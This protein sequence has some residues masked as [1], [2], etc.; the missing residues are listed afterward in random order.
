MTTPTLPRKPRKRALGTPTR[1][2]SLVA[3]PTAIVV[4][5]SGCET[6]TDAVASGANFDFV[7]QGGQTDILYDQPESR[8]MIGVLAGPD[9]MADGSGISV[10]EYAG[11]VVGINLWGQWCAPCRSERSEEYKSELQS[12]VRLMYVVFG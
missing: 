1:A 5:A 3:I 2:L 6:G 10:T 12:L 8:N 9:L 7:S 11:Q 4:A